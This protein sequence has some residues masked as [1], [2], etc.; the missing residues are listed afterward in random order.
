[1]VGGLTALPDG[2]LLLPLIAVF[3][4]IAMNDR[5]LFGEA[6]VNSRVQNLV[7]GAVV[8]V[9]VALGL[10]GLMAAAGSALRMLG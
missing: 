8:L 7:M 1:M 2:L 5:D 6:G 3:L 10:R 9:C 4:W